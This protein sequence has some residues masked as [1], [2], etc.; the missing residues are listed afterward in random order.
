VSDAVAS[1]GAGAGVARRL[2]G[3]T[4]VVTG[5]GA[6]V[7]EGIA[8]TL[9]AEGANVVVAARR[10][11]NGQPVADEIVRRGGSAMCIVT[12]ITRRD[13]V[14]RCVDETVARFGGLEIMVH[15][16]YSGGV[17]HELQDLDDDLWDQNSG[18]AVWATFWC[19]QLAFPHLQRA[20]SRGRLI[21]LTSPSGIEASANLAVYPAVK[22]AQRAIVKTLAHEWGSYGITVNCIAPVAVTPSIGRMFDAVPELRGRVEARMALGRVGEPEHDIG[23]VAAFLAGDGARYVT[24][25]TIVADGGSF[26]GL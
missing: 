21:V 19:A 18:T 12:D 2:D 25:Q 5:G 20:G 8:L 7:G 13:E 6:G 17:A 9:A 4:A 11:E 26:M 14:A 3:R 16:A 15:N 24:G 22:G 23:P 1:T 10:A